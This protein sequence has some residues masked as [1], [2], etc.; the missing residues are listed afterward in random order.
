MNKSNIF[1]KKV[2]FYLG[3]IV[4]KYVKDKL[5][6]YFIFTSGDTH[7]CWDCGLIILLYIIVVCDIDRMVEFYLFIITCW[8]STLRL[9]IINIIYDNKLLIDINI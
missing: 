3:K 4:Q 8:I 5:L 2:E 7:H 6:P 9:Y 1:L